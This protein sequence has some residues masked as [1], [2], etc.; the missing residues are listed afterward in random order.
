MENLGA[1][2]IT[3]IATL[4]GTF[5]GFLLAARS[6]S[7]ADERRSETKM[8]ARELARGLQLEDEHHLIQLETLM[9]LQDLLRLKTRTTLLAMDAD[10]KALEADGTTY[11]LPEELSQEMFKVTIKYVQQVSRVTDKALREKLVL[12]NETCTSYIVPKPVSE[13]NSPATEAALLESASRWLANVAKE[14]TEEL[15]QALRAEIDRRY[16]AG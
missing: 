10:R 8:K 16:S 11:R 9:S 14:L 15:G 3:A 12:F 5:G 2:F 6:Q 13:E 1:T 4:I 7:K